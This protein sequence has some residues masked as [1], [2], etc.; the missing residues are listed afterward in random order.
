VAV[1]G[2]PQEPNGEA[3]AFRPDGLGCYTASEGKA[4][5][6]YFLNLQARDR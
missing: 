1:V 5:P 2:P 3:V 4:Q 6:I